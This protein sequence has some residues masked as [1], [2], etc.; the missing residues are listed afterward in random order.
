MSK[1]EYNW[2]IIAKIET[3]VWIYRAQSMQL[4]F[5][6]LSESP[7]PLTFIVLKSITRKL[8]MGNARLCNSV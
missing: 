3:G 4:Q 5:F 2:I 8:G 6:C 1:L 7:Q